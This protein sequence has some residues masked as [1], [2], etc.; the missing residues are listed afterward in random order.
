MG[1]VG[2]VWLGY[3][4]RAASTFRATGPIDAA[5]LGIHRL[6]RKST[7]RKERRKRS[8]SE[9]LHVAKGLEEKGLAFVM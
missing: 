8:D 3:A 1:V 2:V 7:A 4:G 5:A 9:R 6:L